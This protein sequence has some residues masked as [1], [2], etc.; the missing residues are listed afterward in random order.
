MKRSKKRRAPKRRR[1]SIKRE[2]RQLQYDLAVSDSFAR[3]LMPGCMQFL[4]VA[5]KDVTLR[6][7]AN[8]NHKRPHIH[9]EYGKN[10][11]AASYAIDNGEC[12]A[13][14]LETRRDRL[15]RA[16]IASNRTKLLELWKAA[17]DGKKFDAIVTELRAAA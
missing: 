15:V 11:H 4:V 17:H 6:M 1:L 5:L 13:G 14:D 7:D 10:H 12:L 2:L 8:T 3:P 16:W 9:I